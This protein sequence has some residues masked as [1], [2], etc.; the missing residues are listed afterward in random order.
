M[1]AAH[2]FLGFLA[3]AATIAL[4][5]VAG[6]SAIAVRRD[7][8]GAAHRFAVDRLVLLVVGALASNGLL[9]LVVVGL[10]SRP[11]DVLHLIYGPAALITLPVGVWLGRRPGAG[12]M[13]S[14]LRREA[15]LLGAAVVLLGIEVRL[16]MTG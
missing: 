7:G 11:A 4:L 15:W 6:W 3:V 13:T 14:P 2:Q 9:G 5:A 1:T 10:G 8:G 16:F 12:G